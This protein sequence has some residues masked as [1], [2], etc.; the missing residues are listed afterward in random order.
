MDYEKIVELA[1][2]TINLQAEA[3]LQQIDNLTSIFADVCW[4]VLNSKGK[5]IVTGMGKSGIIGKK[6][7]ST[8]ASTGTPSVFL[9]PGEAFHGDLGMVEEIDVIL[10][11]S[12]SG[13]TDE[14]L[15]LIP[16]F[17]DNG[18]TLISITGVIGSPLAKHSDYHICSKVNKEACPLNL[19]P[20]SSTTA[21]LVL[22]DALSIVLMEMRGF[23]KESF[24]RFHPGGSL[25][26]LLITKVEDVM[27]TGDFPMVNSKSSFLDIIQAITKG[28]F[29]LAVVIDNDKINGIITD[30]DLRRAIEQNDTQIFSL[31]AQDIMTDKP[32]CVQKYTKLKKVNDLLLSKKVNSVLVV[33]NN[34]LIGVLQLYDIGI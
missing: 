26:R 27:K 30:G 5:V 11:I 23:Q 3:V 15:K 32:I 21:T 10:A 16:F 18:N 29:G 1:K 20:T 24:A 13:K 19:A 31:L 28:S 2:A 12:N 7:S 14:V 33:E 25:G 22:G 17:K 34:K 6:I 9:H 8:L 4:E